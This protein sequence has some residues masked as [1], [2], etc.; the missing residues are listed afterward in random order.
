MTNYHL[1]DFPAGRGTSI[2][3]ARNIISKDL[4]RDFIQKIK[5][6]PV[7]QEGRT[8]GGH[9]PSVKKCWDVDFNKQTFD[10]FNVSFDGFEKYYEEFNIGLASAV[11]MYLEDFS[12]LKAAPVLRTTDLHLQK[13]ERNTGFYT[14]HD[15][16]NS[17]DVTSDRTLGI[18]IYLND[19][20]LGGETLFPE[21][22]LRL[23]GFAGDIALFPAN[24]THPH[25]GAFPLS[26]DK[27]IFSVFLKTERCPIVEV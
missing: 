1:L 22:R 6:M 14:V 11:Q 20:A 7:F 26:G 19:V 21:Q 25:C 18:I 16:G 3:V 13:Y 2:A 5:P 15:D 27:W 10:S 4:C 17:W 23:K 9:K 12:F 24:W 8:L